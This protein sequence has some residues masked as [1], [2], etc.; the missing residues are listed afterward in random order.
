MK[1]GKPH[2]KKTGKG[3]LVIILVDFNLLFG[4][5]RN[6]ATFCL[7]NFGLILGLKRLSFKVLVELLMWST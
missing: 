5:M 2:C 7:V 3:A 4:T 6:L 1:Q